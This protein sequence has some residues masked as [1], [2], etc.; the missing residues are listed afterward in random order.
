MVLPARVEELYKALSR[1]IR[2]LLLHS[3]GQGWGGRGGVCGNKP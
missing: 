3:I 1:V 2:L